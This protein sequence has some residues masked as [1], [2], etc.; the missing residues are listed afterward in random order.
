MQVRTQGINHE[1]WMEFKDRVS[2]TLLDTCVD[3]INNLI[4]SMPRHINAVMA[5][6]GY[7]TKY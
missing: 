7:R 2:K 1:T 6:K 5:G 3:F 4:T